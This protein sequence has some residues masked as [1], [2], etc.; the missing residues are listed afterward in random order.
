MF[1]SV[2]CQ[3][4]SQEKQLLVKRKHARLWRVRLLESAGLITSCP[5]M[6][7]NNSKSSLSQLGS[8]LILSQTW[9]CAEVKKITTSPQQLNYRC[10]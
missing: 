9:L 10:R 7:A 1:S 3:E 8:W 4:P 6:K 2:G 5:L